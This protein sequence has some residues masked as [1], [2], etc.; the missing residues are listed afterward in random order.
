MLISFHIIKTLIK[1]TKMSEQVDTEIT[2]ILD[3]Y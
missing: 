2:G 1:L 3:L